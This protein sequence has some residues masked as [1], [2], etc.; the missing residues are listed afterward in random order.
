VY[1]FVDRSEFFLYLNAHFR[2]DNS[3][4]NDPAWHALRNTVYAS[5]CRIVLS[6]DD[7]LRYSDIQKEA[8]SYFQNAMSVH[9]ELLFT[10][11][12]LMAVRALI[13]MVCDTYIIYRPSSKYANPC[14][15]DLFY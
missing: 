4:A 6:K 1:G 7:S 15:V 2:K 9:T 14:H 3:I 12:S 11:T 13:A 10:F 8:W 5:G